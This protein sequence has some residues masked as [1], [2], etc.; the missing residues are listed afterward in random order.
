MAENH[1]GSV[2]RLEFIFYNAYTNR[3]N[4]FYNMVSIN[5]NLT[6]VLYLQASF[7]YN[8]HDP[9]VKVPCQY[10]Y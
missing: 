7:L 1:A 2:E 4:I 3:K 10:N 9:N 8:L 6:C 5:M